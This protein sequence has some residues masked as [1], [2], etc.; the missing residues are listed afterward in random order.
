SPVGIAMQHAVQGERGYGLVADYRG[1]RVA[2][3]WSYLPSFRWGLVVKQDVA[4]AFDLIYH[5]RLAT[6]AL[7]GGTV[8]IVILAALLGARGLSR[9]IQDAV[10]VAEQVAAGDLTA[11]VKTR[12]TGEPGKLL[13]AVETMTKDL[14][15]LIGRIQKSS[16]ALLSTA[17]EIAATSRQQ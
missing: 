16:I 2:A 9:P 13:E 4:E 17:T 8:L 11:Q 12:A 14:R 6:A 7:L 10:R 1:H 3:A 15:A 5:Q